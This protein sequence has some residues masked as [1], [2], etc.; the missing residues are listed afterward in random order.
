MNSWKT[1][2]QLNKWE[3]KKSVINIVLAYLVTIMFTLFFIR[4]FSSYMENGTILFDFLFLLLFSSSPL[5]P[6]PKNFEV[7][8]LQNGLFASPIVCLRKQLPIRDEVII[9]SRLIMHIL[10]TFPIQVVALLIL[11][12]ATPLTNILS[13]GSFLS[14]CMIWL[15]ISISL[16]Y[17]IPKL[18]I[19][20]E[21]LAVT[22]VGS[23]ITFTLLTLLTFMILTIFHVLFGHGIVYWSIVFANN[24]PLLAAGISI[25]IAV[26]GYKAWIGSMRKALKKLRYG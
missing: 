18:N 4:E 1:A 3:I 11:Y 2:F 25:I 12:L 13:V 15:A 23:L 9:T 22:N 14:F 21:G 17:S 8:Q 10:Y 20:S 19:G 16:G 5:F 7:Q 26:I 24:L 6:K